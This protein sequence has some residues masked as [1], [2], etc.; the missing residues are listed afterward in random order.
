MSDILP[1]PFCQGPATVRIGMSVQVWCYE[2][3]FSVTGVKRWNTRAPSGP[4]VD[5]SEAMVRAARLAFADAQ[6]NDNSGP[7]Q[8]MVAAVRAAFRAVEEK[9]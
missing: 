1:C 5:V 7:Q 3:G 9:P 6:G 2:C 8:W 4:R